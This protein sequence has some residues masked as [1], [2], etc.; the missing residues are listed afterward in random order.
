MLLDPKSF[1]AGP[2]RTQ[3]VLEKLTSRQSERINNNK[4]YGLT[5]YY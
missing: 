2:K 1:A 5:L 4:T 3:A